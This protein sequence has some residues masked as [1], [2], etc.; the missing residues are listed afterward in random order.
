MKS[1]RKLTRV[2]GMDVMRRIYDLRHKGFNYEDIKRILF[3]EFEE[4]RFIF[5]ND[6]TYILWLN[7]WIN[8]Y[9]LQSEYCG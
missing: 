8:C 6:S 5:D 2:N 9:R 3:D 4:A 7:N 1:T